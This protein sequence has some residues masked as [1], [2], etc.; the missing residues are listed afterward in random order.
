M[1]TAPPA[2]RAQTHALQTHR[3]VRPLHA[4]RSDGPRRLGSATIA[5][6]Q[7]HPHAQAQTQTKTQ[8]PPQAFLAA[9]AP[10]H[11][12]VERWRL[13]VSADGAHP[14]PAPPAT[15]VSV[16]G[17]LQGEASPSPSLSHSTLTL[18][19]RTTRR[20]GSGAARSRWAEGPGQVQSQWGPATGSSSASASGNAGSGLRAHAHAATTAAPRQSPTAKP[21]RHRNQYFKTKLCRF[22]SEPGGCVKGDRCNFIHEHPDEG[23]RPSGLA[24]PAPELVSEG[25]AESAAESSVLE[26]APSTEATSEHTP[27]LESPTQKKSNFYPVT[28]R[29]VGGGVMMSGHRE[30]CESFMAGRCSEGAE[31]RYAHPETSEEDYYAGYR[32][33]PPMY[34]PISPLLSPVIYAYPVV[35]PTLSPPQPFALAAMPGNV[36]PAASVSPT[37]TLSIPVP[38]LHMPQH[39]TAAQSGL[40]ISP[41]IQVQPSGVPYAYSPHRVVDGTTLIERDGVGAHASDGLLNAARAVVRPVSTPPTPMQGPEA[42]VARVRAPSAPVYHSRAVVLIIPCLG[43]CGWPTAVRCG[44]AVTMPPARSEHR[45]SPLTCGPPWSSQMAARPPSSSSVSRP[46]LAFGACEDV[47]HATPGVKRYLVASATSQ[48]PR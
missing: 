26:E 41:V 7:S 10:P 33:P 40:T 29:V 48:P 12:D 28:W 30:V 8:T 32:E 46:F 45:S 23:R 15:P 34:S 2:Y 27:S 19:T 37:D 16:P 38:P 1:C 4:P 44:D 31:C 5:Q 17:G 47:M 22:Y 11:T 36:P 6:P 3:D 24:A 35:Y 13:A 14:P 42:G 18:S 9:N 25:E 39:G 43:L 20:D 21:A